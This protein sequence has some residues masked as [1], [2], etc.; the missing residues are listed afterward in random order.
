MAHP[1]EFIAKVK[2]LYS[3]PEEISLDTIKLV[4][5]RLLE[6]YSQPQWLG[7]GIIGRVWSF[8]DITERK[9]A[10]EAPRTSEM[11]SRALIEAVPDMLFR[12]NQDGVYLDAQISDDMLLHGDARELYRN[13]AL[14]GKSIT[15]VLPSPVDVKLMDGITKA[16]VGNKVV[17]QEYS[18]MAEDQKIYF[19]A[20][21]APSGDNEVVSIVRDVTDRIRHEKELTYISLHDQL[22]G[23]YNR[24][25]FENEIKRLDS[26][27]EHP[28][29]VISADLDGLKLVNDTL[30]H[31]EGD[32]YL[33]AGQSF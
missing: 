32:R 11:R 19:E 18:Y 16:L 30:G 20:R 22:T 4:D 1:E 26:S 10:E 23:L 6:R 33:Q 21:L 27:R 7:E 2:A 14:I 12:Y 28:I 25:Y 24:R 17:I 13:N 9:Q 3:S 15:E 29:A 5:G 31:S 8:R